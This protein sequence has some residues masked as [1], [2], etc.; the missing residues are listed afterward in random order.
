M[1]T[2][3]SY[4]AIFTIL[5]ILLLSNI[6]YSIVP[7]PKDQARVYF[8]GQ[9]PHNS[10]GG[11]FNGDLYL[12]VPET[13]EIIMVPDNESALGFGGAIGY[14]KIGRNS[15]G[16]AVEIG[17]QHSSHDY[18]YVGLTGK[19]SLN[20]L[21][22]DIKGIFSYTPVE[23]YLLV[24]IGIPWLSIENGSDFGT[25][26]PVDA[27]Y[28]GVGINLGAGLDLFLIP[29]LSFGGR[30]VYRYISYSQVKGSGEKIKI[31]DG[32]GGSGVQICGNLT[33]HVPIE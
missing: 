14:T 3:K 19:S 32:V 4:S 10:I 16:Y 12:S 28:S 25:A 20:I 8:S 7:R 27:K 26:N 30:V 24:G 21:N 5:I 13:G 33:F 17:F 29:N 23:P 18:T 9:L 22:F 31:E 11:D 15:L 2:N 1:K 6:A